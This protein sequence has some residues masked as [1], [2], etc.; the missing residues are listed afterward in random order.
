VKTKEEKAADNLRKKS[1]RLSYVKKAIES[2]EIKTFD[3]IFS[4]V[5]ETAFAELMGINF[6]GFRQKAKFPGQ[7]TLHEVNRMAALLSTSYGVVHEFLLNII[8]IKGQDL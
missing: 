7:F 4:I 1:N 6:Y 3:Q 5:S 2:Q 8:K